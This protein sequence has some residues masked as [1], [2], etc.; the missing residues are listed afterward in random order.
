MSASVADRQSGFQ[1]RGRMFT[2]TVFELHDP[3]VVSLAMQL[4]RHVE[5]APD[6]FKD[7]PV[8]IDLAPLEDTHKHVDF[9]ALVSLL[10]NYGLNVIGVCGGNDQQRQAAREARLP[11]FKNTA[12][13]KRPESPSPAEEAP[14]AESR[15]ETEAPA[16]KAAEAVPTEA[17][18]VNQPVRSGQRIYARGRDLVILAPVSAG[19]EVIADGHIHV[20]GP[21]RGRA[22]AGA[23]GE[24]NAGIFCQSLEAE[25]VSVLGIYKTRDDL[26]SDSCW[27][28]PAQITLENDNLMIRPLWG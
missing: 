23:T 28:Q 7:M 20:Y 2:L 8:V 13:A 19:A 26:E 18:V 22:I 3:A 15:A 27:K 12:D 14:A 1:L 4:R 24:L 16:E 25:L 17:M 11:L 21:L 10:G 6:F 5:Q 9:P